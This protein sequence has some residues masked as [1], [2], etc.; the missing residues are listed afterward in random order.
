MHQA[1]LAALLLNVSERFSSDDSSIKAILAVVQLS[2]MFVSDLP[3]LI[4]TST[5]SVNRSFLIASGAEEMGK[6][7]YNLLLL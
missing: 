7:P 2:R 1:C 5:A 3:D 6:P 4:S